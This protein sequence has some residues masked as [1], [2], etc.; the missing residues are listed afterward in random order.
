MHLRNN[1]SLNNRLNIFSLS[2]FYLKYMQQVSL[3]QQYF[4]D[5]EDRIL[6]VL[7]T[8]GFN[9]QMGRRWELTH[10]VILRV[11]WTCAGWLHWFQIC[12][13]LPEKLL[14]LPFFSIKYFKL[15]VWYGP[16][17][18]DLLW[19]YSQWHCWYSAPWEEKLSILPFKNYIFL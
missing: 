10:E 1:F 19:S 12:K 18:F 6:L 7:S 4:H 9:W 8:S 13:L 11:L 15:A 14:I 2:V 17:C 3:P 16:H 5:L